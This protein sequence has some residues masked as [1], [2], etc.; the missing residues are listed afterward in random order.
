MLKLLEK[1]P[2]Y[3]KEWFQFLL[4]VVERFEADKCRQQAGS[5]TYT[6]LFAVVPMLTVFLVII[7]SIKALA[8]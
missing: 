6:T 7:S 1:L 2:F 3:H 5:L 8:P 4:F